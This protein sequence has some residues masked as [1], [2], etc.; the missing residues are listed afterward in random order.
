MPH[1]SWSCQ[2]NDNWTFT[3]NQSNRRLGV[4]VMDAELDTGLK[5]RQTSTI[6]K[7]LIVA[8]ILAVLVILTLGAGLVWMVRTSREV[9]ASR[10]QSLIATNTDFPFTPPADGRMSEK[11]FQSWMRVAEQLE[12]LRR[13]RGADLRRPGE[14]PTVVGAV[15]F[16]L[17][18]VPNG[19]EDI[20][21]AL[22]DSDMSLDEF[23]WI[24][25][26]L[27]AALRHEA[28]ATHPAI[29]G[30]VH[31]IDA[32]SSGPQ[33]P[34]LVERDSGPPPTLDEREASRLLD[35]IERYQTEFEAIAPVTFGDPL[36]LMAVDRGGVLVKVPP[37]TTP[38]R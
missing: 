26:Q 27:Q 30:I 21:S 4:Q 29:A 14:Q 13:A 25:H 9:V 31:S 28:A 37:R 3:A 22:R 19:I 38:G 20:D 10:Q 7:V 2:L 23:G 1:L 11:R 35:L 8:G 16:G 5:P 17:N 15:T 32:R 36:V 34:G 12:D 6:K 18:A 33:P 24:L